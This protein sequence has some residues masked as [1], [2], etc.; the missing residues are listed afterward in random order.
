MV[1][2]AHAEDFYLGETPEVPN[3][4]L[5]PLIVYRE[6]VGGSSDLAA[7]LEKI[8]ASNGWVPAWRYGIHPFPHYH[9]TAHE[10]IGVYRG[11]ATVRFGHTSEVEIELRP[12]DVVVLPAG[13]GHEC[14]SATPDFHAVGAYPEGQEPDLIRADSSH[15]AEA[16]EQIDRV[17]LPAADPVFGERGPLTDLW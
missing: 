1:M 8:F 3:N 13:T 4:P 2:E 12:G 10:V 5:L 6:A 14:L 9:S 7:E 15:A 17:P 11:R 16:A